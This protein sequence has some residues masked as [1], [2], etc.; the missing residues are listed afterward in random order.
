MQ[1]SCVLL[2][3]S[4]TTRCSTSEANPSR[5]FLDLHPRPSSPVDNKHNRIEQ[6]VPGRSTAAARGAIIQ[7]DVIAEGAVGGEAVGT[8]NRLGQQA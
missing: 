5:F 8:R 1:T 2:E 7:K 3:N 6:R 4:N